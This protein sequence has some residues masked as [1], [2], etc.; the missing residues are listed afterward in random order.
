[1]SEF[2]F[3]EESENSDMFAAKPTPDEQTLG[4]WDVLIVDDD[5]AVHNIT[6]TV[7]KSKV[8]DGKKLRFHSV[9]SGREATDLL[10][11]Q[12]D[13]AVIL[14][15]VVM[16]HDQAGLEACRIIRDELELN[17]VRIILRTGQPG[18]T[19][20]EEVILKYRINDY[21]EKNELTA[22]KLFSCIVTA[23][24]SYHDL[25]SLEQSK[26]Q[27][28]NEKE[29]VEAVNVKI[30][31]ATQE[32]KRNAK[33]LEVAN[34]YKSQF[35]ANMS[36]EL[37][38]PLNSI[39]ILSKL[40]SD[41]YE[42][43]LIPD[44]LESVDVIYNSGTELL[45]LIDDILELSQLETGQLSVNYDNHHISELTNCIKQEF[46]PKAQ[47]KSLA[48]SLKVSTTIPEKIIIDIQKVKQVL[49]NLLANSF[50]FTQ[51]GT[52]ALMV[53]YTDNPQSALIF[54]VLDTGIGIDAEQLNGIFETFQQVD[55]ST[56]RQYGGTGL[57]LAISKEIV[58]LLKGNLSVSSQLDV[59]SA[60]T[61]TVP[62]DHANA[63]APTM[64]MPEV[65]NI[66]KRSMAGKLV[67]LVDDNPRNIYSLKQGLKPFN[68]NFIVAQN[69]LEALD[70]LADNPSID[71]VLMDIMMPLMDGNTAIKAIRQLQNFTQ[72]PIIAVTA[73]ATRADQR[74]AI[75][76]GANDCMAKPVD[77]HALTSLMASYLEFTEQA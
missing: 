10:K 13:F 33:Q 71:I 36:H 62:L 53:D 56:S 38:T 59:G 31:A 77:I 2:L 75:S 25:V 58:K 11:H 12:S 47:Q 65:K 69:G 32:I 30:A 24:R 37:R 43:N 61:L 14:L 16:E 52:V 23:V 48:F 44:Q 63:P 46:A 27:L 54:K 73:K 41:N 9:F 72:L 45:A 17:T 19:P 66:Q 70:K 29:A 64:F 3:T 15:D 34:R 1:M 8:I 55:G 5:E 49:T 57:G 6:K 42:K 22:S 60:F 74:Q 50:K 51:V 68:M 26:L 39:L 35:L 40:L 18:S 20:E 4:Y 21:K 28:I 67:L 7:L 76:S